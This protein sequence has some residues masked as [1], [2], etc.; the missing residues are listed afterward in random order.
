M[1]HDHKATCAVWTADYLSRQTVTDVQRLLIACT[2]GFCGPARDQASPIHTGLTPQLLDQLHSFAGALSSGDG[3]HSSSNSSSMHKQEMFNN[4]RCPMLHCTVI[5]CITMALRKFQ[6][7]AEETLLRGLY[8]MRVPGP[9]FRPSNTGSTCTRM[10]NASERK[11]VCDSLEGT[12]WGLVKTM[13]KINCNV[14]AL[15]QL[16]LEHIMRQ[17]TSCEIC[18]DN[19]GSSA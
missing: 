19:G 1:F 15:C 4:K 10:A 14:K 18:M 5:R 17:K 6:T 11:Q 9:P 7:S 2:T 16:K 12:A 8:L 13:L 3:S